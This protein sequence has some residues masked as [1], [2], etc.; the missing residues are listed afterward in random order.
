MAETFAAGK[1]ALGICDRCGFTQKLKDLKEETVRMKPTGFKVCPSCFSVDHPQNMQ[2]L[3]PVYDPEALRD[4]RPDTDKGRDNTT[5]LD[6][7]LLKI[8]PGN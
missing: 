4:P 7:S 8:G 5:A 6:F 1:H 2:G 3:H